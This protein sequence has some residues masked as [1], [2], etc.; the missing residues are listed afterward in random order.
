MKAY[1]EK[2]REND[3]S[4]H[5]NVK[6][7]LFFKPHF[8]S[9]I[10]ILIV[11][12]GNF[13]VQ[14]NGENYSVCDGQIFIND[15]Y[16]IH[17]YG[18]NDGGDFRL[19]II[20]ISFAKKFLKLKGDNAISSPVISC[21]QLALSLTEI[22]DRIFRTSKNENVIKASVDLFFALIFEHL[23]L[24][25]NKR[26]SQYSLIKNILDYLSRN[27]NKD[28]TLVSVAKEFGYTEAHI[29]RLFHKFFKCSIC[30][31]VNNLRINYV[32]D[33]INSGEV[34]VTDAIFESGFNSVQTYYRN[35]A[36][37]KKDI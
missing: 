22:I 21:P 16:D 32:L 19:V 4:L 13:T 8:H 12:K 23:E 18:H 31:Y 29:S 7:D 28:V 2:Y 9:N 25:A 26:K 6:G 37:Y 5:F 30:V 1:L 27:F 24:C 33:R 17:G 34:N 15:C 20:P 11:N 14:N 36:R 35:L 10:E 3:N